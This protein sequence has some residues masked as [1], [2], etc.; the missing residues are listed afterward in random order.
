MALYYVLWLFTLYR[1]V[2]SNSNMMDF[3]LSYYSSFHLKKWMSEW[4]NKI[5]VTRI[6]VN[7][8]SGNY[9][10]WEKENYSSPVQCHIVQDRPHVDENLNYIYW[11]NSLSQWS[12][13][14]W[15]SLGMALGTKKC[16]VSLFSLLTAVFCTC[17][18]LVQRIFEAPQIKKKDPLHTQFWAS[19][20]L[21]YLHSLITI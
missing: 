6:K 1:F 2:S 4:M 12:V 7:N 13:R 15:T 11:G 8:W 9:T 20:E 19:V 16:V 5:L 18:P 3:V 10:S 14:C 21:S 17:C